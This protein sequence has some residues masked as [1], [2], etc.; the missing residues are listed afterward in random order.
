[1]DVH[2]GPLTAQKSL[3]TR[4]GVV[5]DKNTMRNNVIAFDNVI[6]THPVRVYSL[7]VLDMRILGR[8]NLGKFRIQIHAKPVLC[9]HLW[10]LDLFRFGCS[11][12][13][14]SIP[15]RLCTQLL[16]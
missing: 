3:M 15:E 12:Q 14:V 7:F 11:L 9:R 8:N 10:L 4:S 16:C 2:S 13:L 1:M 5:P 6:D